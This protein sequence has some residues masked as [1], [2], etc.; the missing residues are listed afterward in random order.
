MFENWK[1]HTKSMIVSHFVT[2]RYKRNTIYQI[3]RRYE[4]TGT[5]AR[6]YGQG[7]KPV[8]MGKKKKKALK[9]MFNNHDGVSTRNAGKKFGCSHTHIRKT[10]LQMGVNIT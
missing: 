3:I 6:Q 9:Q 4:K 1:L 8:I 10:L 7:R 2:E 5:W